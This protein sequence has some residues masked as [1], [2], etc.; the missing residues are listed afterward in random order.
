MQRRFF[1]IGGALG[2]VAGCGG[3][4]NPFK[5]FQRQPKVAVE[6]APETAD[7]RGLMARL[8]EV[9]IE[10]TTS[11]VLLRATGLAPMQGYYDAELV[12]LPLDESG[13]KTFEFRVS[14]PETPTGPGSERTRQITAAVAI[15][16]YQLGLARSIRVV[17]AENAM[18]ISP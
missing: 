11:G 17:A 7:P 1:L 8:L 4:L 5:W 6:A 10:E 15:T 14:P 3:R 18:T 2:L 12:G 16:P 13:V 9:K